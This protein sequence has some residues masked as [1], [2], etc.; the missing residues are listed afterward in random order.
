MRGNAASHGHFAAFRIII[1]RLPAGFGG[2]ELVLERE[3]AARLK[4][5]EL[6]LALFDQ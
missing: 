1:P 5:F 3:N 4:R 6:G 2:R